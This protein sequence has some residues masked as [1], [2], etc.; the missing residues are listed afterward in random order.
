MHTKHVCPVQMYSA[1]PGDTAFTGNTLQ[2][3][4]AP[5]VNKEG[6]ITMYQPLILPS[7]PCLLSRASQSLCQA[8]D[9]HGRWRSGRQVLASWHRKHL[10]SLPNANC[11]QSRKHPSAFIC[12]VHSGGV[13]GKGEGR[14]KKWCLNFPRSDGRGA[15]C[16][17]SKLKVLLRV[18]G[19][20][21]C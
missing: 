17:K 2:F 7:P 4:P 18:A 13:C 8:P 5:H 3:G 16:G 14:H 12:K 21:P 1:A 11:H 10:L 6:T 19:C 15:R 20:S 9:A